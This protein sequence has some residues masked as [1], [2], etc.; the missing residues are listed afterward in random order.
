MGEVVD[1]VEA[2]GALVIRVDELDIDELPIEEVGEAPEE[3][4]LKVKT[5]V[6]GK[7]VE[8]VPKDKV[9]EIVLKG[10]LVEIVPVDEILNVTDDELAPRL[11]YIFKAFE[12]PQYSSGLPMQVLVQAVDPTTLP[13]LGE[14]PQ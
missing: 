6:V 1:E 5:V 10:E 7:S 2:V 3:S 9:I 8:V 4:V 12:P 14:L 11:L 13:A